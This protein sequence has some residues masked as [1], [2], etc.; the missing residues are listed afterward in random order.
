MKDKLFHKNL[1]IYEIRNCVGSLYG[2]IF[3][4]ALPLLMS[5][6]FIAA[7][8]EGTAA[9]KEQIAT[10]IF[11][12]NSLMIPLALMYIGFGTGFSIEIEKDILARI[13]LFGYSSKMIMI[14]K[15]TA[16]FLIQVVITAIYVVVIASIFPI[17]VPG[18][19]GIIHVILNYTILTILFF[20]LSYA[21]A[22][23]MGKYGPTYGI[24]MSTYF[25]ILILSGLMGIELDK[26]PVFL[27]KIAYLLPTTYFSN[28]MI[29]IWQG[30][31]Y[32]YMPIIQSYIGI[33]A[34]VGILLFIGFRKRRA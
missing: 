9:V 23:I 15:L 2:I 27:Q 30:N 17:Q 25:I 12:K 19:F 8:S 29:R 21:I 13:N 26:F 24:T 6:I 7:F 3:A 14:A 10:G 33:A 31:S 18:S 4:G 32:N 11:L 28:D 22:L 20:C 34:L 5:I 1:I 16:Y